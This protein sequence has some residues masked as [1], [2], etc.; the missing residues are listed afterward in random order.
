MIDHTPQADIIYDKIEEIMKR[1]Y[2]YVP[3]TEFVL[4]DVEDE[5]KE[6][7]LYYHS[8]KLAIAHGLI[9]TL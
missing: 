8:E 9:S 3:D 4:L 1:E 5:E 7:S 6:R 2:G